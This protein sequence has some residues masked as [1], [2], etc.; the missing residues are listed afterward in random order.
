MC[1]WFTILARCYDNNISQKG[2]QLS[3]FFVSV[4]KCGV[5]G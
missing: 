4:D 2:T 5:V 1:Q 3:A